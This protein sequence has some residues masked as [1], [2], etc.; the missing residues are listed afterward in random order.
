MSSEPVKTISGY[1]YYSDKTELP[2]NSTL[3]VS[4][5]DVSKQDVPAKV[6]DEQ[7]TQNADTAGL[8]FDLSYRPADALD[9]HT[10]AI[11]AQITCGE[12][13]IYTTTEQHQ[14]F[15]DVDYLQPQRIWVDCV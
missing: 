8:G 4:L 10:Y 12:R 5:V 6:L 11:S 15:L 2:K 1:V 14:V 13:L 3:R 9:G 7:V